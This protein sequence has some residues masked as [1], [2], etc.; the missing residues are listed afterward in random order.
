[1]NLTFADNKIL[2]KNFEKIFTPFWFDTCVNHFDQF[3]GMK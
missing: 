1:M 3:N 2:T